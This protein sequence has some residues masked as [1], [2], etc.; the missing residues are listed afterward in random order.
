[1]YF[2]LEN[3]DE[4]V[5]HT[6]HDAAVSDLRNLNLVSSLAFNS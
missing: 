3:V 2:V 6:P 5:V 4:T 1:M